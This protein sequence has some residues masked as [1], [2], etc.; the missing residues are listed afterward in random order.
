MRRTAPVFEFATVGATGHQ[1]LMNPKTILLCAAA[2]LATMTLSQSIR[3]AETDMPEIKAEIGK[4]RD[5]TIRRL[6]EWIKQPSIAAENRGVEEG[7]ELNG[8][9]LSEVCDVSRRW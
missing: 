4:Q 6:Q 8:I 2:V 3:S 7:C 1:S 5:A 9:K